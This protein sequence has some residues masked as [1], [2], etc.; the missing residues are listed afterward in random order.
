MGF[1]M[2]KT[3]LFKA[4][5][6]VFQSRET[7]SSIAA[8]VTASNVRLHGHTTDYHHMVGNSPYTQ[9]T[10]HITQLGTVNTSPLPPDV[11]ALPTGGTDSLPPISSVFGMN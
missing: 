2:A 11:P 3:T 6:F 8:P 1:F 10:P 5:L 9:D 4:S 7:E